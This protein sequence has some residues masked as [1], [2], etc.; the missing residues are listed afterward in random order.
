MYLLFRLSPEWTERKKCPNQW[1][2]DQRLVFYFPGG[3]KD[4]Q[5]NTITNESMLDDSQFSSEVK[6]RVIVWEVKE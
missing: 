3:L 1:K 2:F 5:S 4:H 6:I